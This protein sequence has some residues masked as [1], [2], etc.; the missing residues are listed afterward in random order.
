MCVQGVFGILFIFLFFVH[1]DVGNQ[2]EN[3]MGDKLKMK[4]EIEDGT[5]KERR[6]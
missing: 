4:D 2:K 5:R 6:N 3:E 1:D